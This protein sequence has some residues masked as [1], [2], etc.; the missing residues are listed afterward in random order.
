MNK[1][2]TYLALL[3]LAGVLTWMVWPGDSQAPDADTSLTTAPRPE[4]PVQSGTAAI[5]Q[6]S[7]SLSP[8]V[9]ESTQ[10][11]PATDQTQ[12]GAV[13]EAGTASIVS[14]RRFQGHVLDEAVSST[15]EPGVYRRTL[16][17][18]TDFHYPLVRIEETVRDPGTRREQILSSIEAVAGHILVRIREGVT[19]E[20]L[21]AL[22]EP[23]PAN[24]EKAHVLSRLYVVNIPARTVDDLPR[25]LDFLN[26][27]A[28]VEYAE[29]DG[30]VHAHLTEP[31]DPRYLD[32]TLW[33]LHN[34]GQD[35]GTA[36]KDIDAPE[37]WDIRHSAENVIVAVIDTGILYTHEDLAGNM[38][39]NTSELNGLPG[40][41]DDANGY[42]DDIYG[43]NSITEGGD[44]IDDNRHGTHCAGTIGG[45]GDNATGV[46]GV[47]WE[48]Q[49]M[50][51]K[52]LGAG[53]S[54][55]SSDAAECVIYAVANGASVLSNS[56]GGGSFNATLEA[57]IEQAQMAD[58]IFVAAAGNNG[59]N[60]DPAP[61]YPVA[62]PQSNIVGVASYNREGFRSSFS[63]YGPATIEVAAPGS[64]IF[65]STYSGDPTDIDAYEPLSGTSMATPHVSGIIALMRA[66]FPS[67][68]YQ[69]LINRLLDSADTTIMGS[70]VISGGANLPAALTG[71]PSGPYND[72]FDRARYLGKRSFTT[73]GTTLLATAEPGEPS[74]AGQPASHSVWF[75]WVA[76]MANIIDVYSISDEMDTRIAVYE[77]TSL[78]SLTEIASNDNDPDAVNSGR[79]SFLQFPAT[80]NQTYFIAVDSADGSTGS[81]SLSIENTP[82]NDDFA[83]AIAWSGT[84]GTFRPDNTGATKEPGEPRHGGLFGGS[85]LWYTFT[86][87][88]DGRLRVGNGDGSPVDLG[89]GIY[90]GTEVSALAELG[91]ARADRN[92]TANAYAFLEAGVPY[93]I[94]VDTPDGKES[95][96][97]INWAFTSNEIR[98]N[99][100]EV[101]VSE[102]DPSG[103]V[104]IPVERYLGTGSG[105]STQVPWGTSS[106]PNS[107]V[108]GLDYEE[109]S[110]VLAWAANEAG[111]KTISIPILD[112][113]QIQGDRVL[114]LTLGSPTN[115]AYVNPAYRRVK[116]TILDDD[117]PLPSMPGIDTGYSFQHDPLTVFAI[118]EAAWIPVTR[119]GDAS[120]AGSV[121]LDTSDDSALN[122]SDYVATSV[123]VDFEP[124]QTI[125]FVPVE[126]LSPTV[127]RRFLVS[128]SNPG[129]PASV[130]LGS[131]T[132]SVEFLGASTPFLDPITVLSRDN[133]S[134]TPP[135]AS[136]TSRVDVSANG[137]FTV[138]DSSTNALVPGD[139]NG[140][141][142]VFLR[143]EATGAL[144][145]VSTSRFGGAGDGDSTHP[146]ISSDGRYI[147]YASTANDIHSSDANEHSDI[148]IFDRITGETVLASVNSDGDQAQKKYVNLEEPVF[149]D[150]THPEI[151]G[152]GMSII[153]L[154][155]AT[156]LD[157]LH[158]SNDWD[159]DVFVRDLDTGVTEYASIDSNWID[160]RYD[161]ETAA[162]SH[163][164]QII[165]FT[166]NSPDLVPDDGNFT[167][168]DIFLRDR[169]TNTTSL[170]SKL[171]GGGSHDSFGGFISVA[172]SGNG[173]KIAFAT[174]IPGWAGEA[175]NEFDLNIFVRDIATG[176]ITVVNRDLSGSR[177]PGY[178]ADGQFLAFS[179]DGS[180]LAFSFSNPSLLPYPVSTSVKELLYVSHLPS[181]SLYVS[182][183][184]AD[185]SLAYGSIGPMA[186]T[187]DGASVVFSSDMEGL[188]SGG[189]PSSS[190]VFG[191]PSMVNDPRTRF[192]FNNS[193][194]QTLK[195]EGS[196]VIEIPVWRSGNLAHAV[197]IAYQT[198]A[199]TATAGIDY[200]PVSGSLNFAAGESMKS[201]SITTFNPEGS[202]PPRNFF[203]V[204]DDAPSDFLFPA[205]NRH[206]IEL[207][208]QLGLVTSLIRISRT[209][210]DTGG[211][212]N[213]DFPSLDHTGTMAVF[214]SNATNLVTEPAITTDNL[215]LFD[216]TDASLQLLP[217][218][219]HVPGTETGATYPV[220]SGDANWVAFRSNVSGLTQEG[221]VPSVYQLYLADL[222][223]GAIRLLS[224]DASGNPG[225]G[226]TNLYS[227]SSTTLD[228]RKHPFSVNED[229]R[230]VA[231]HSTAANLVPSDANS[232]SDIFLYDR[233]NDSLTRIDTAH[234]G[235]PSAGA[236]YNPSVSAD[237]R[238]V[239]FVSAKPDLVPDDTNGF[240]DV[241][242]YDRLT[243]TIE[244][245]SIADDEAEANGPSYNCSISGDGDLVAF[246]SSATNLIGL[247]DTNGY[248]DC[249]VRDMTSGTTT[250][251]SVTSNGTETVP[252]NFGYKLDG[253]SFGPAISADG[254]HVAFTS[255]AANLD[256][257]VQ[258][259]P[260]LQYYLPNEKLY[261]H[262]RSSGETTALIPVDNADAYAETPV[263]SAD[264]RIAAIWSQSAALI[265]NDNNARYDAFLAPNPSHPAV[266]ASGFALWQV[267]HFYHQAGNPEI[268]GVSADPEGDL[269]PNII[270]YVLGLNPI[271]FDTPIR[272][273]LRFG[274]DPLSD[275]LEFSFPIKSTIN[276]ITWR[277]AQSPSLEPGSWSFLGDE[278][279]RTSFSEDSQDMDRIHLFVPKPETGFRSFFQ[280]ELIP[281]SSI[282]FGTPNE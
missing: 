79:D 30:I 186:M 258:F 282:D 56:W 191:G 270:E 76:P 93:F 100:L 92:D 124:G 51:C 50:A 96:F 45:S 87:A 221:S 4:A 205:G 106:A 231:F 159:M 6:A 273:F 200:D 175:T 141:S 22:L 183:V 174:M 97:F 90:S 232:S 238:F 138:F 259:P 199:G 178:S 133:A 78:G 99:D 228:I 67:E 73:L 224:K 121:Q 233:D 94:A 249:F 15:D 155:D 58:V 145:L 132:A 88:Y 211:N 14:Q 74:H 111:I 82:Q 182:S 204:L 123:R 57:A 209:A 239:A 55:S 49:L 59:Q 213:S 108:D 246:D 218:D 189:N 198:E 48:V 84:G 35:E 171:P 149:T 227:G 194:S 126:L 219:P 169:N 163:D 127:G 95:W 116:I 184:A 225:N 1:P 122:G 32:G 151:S 167:K 241:F 168:D 268:G 230:F 274:E 240:A 254:G 196:S 210:T 11:N 243:G 91:G 242:R 170:L 188:A 280:L 105:S 81:F 139:N 7:P 8:I 147:A 207:L 18:Q 154:S 120:E 215:F 112:N 46:T 158:P 252:F 29:A 143:D 202:E 28:Q 131:G 9:P 261:L 60:I 214:S 220:I 146:S 203:L 2:L 201:I 27:Q 119:I 173:E 125:A 257:S 180:Y 77:G 70:S 85:S 66:Q 21:E 244:R 165:V 137:R 40:V 134:G 42:I 193:T 197:T 236:S 16:L 47:A 255:Y 80:N 281:A 117:N 164:G 190:D 110:G 263:L 31:N 113:P 222:R 12:G 235:G 256:P 253:N 277:I 5:P 69:S 24:I 185:D 262:N 53:G 264:G 102:D 192:F 26:K 10:A 275:D 129:S 135:G 115:G 23:I 114:Y 64:N 41:D 271:R 177:M 181:G 250:R 13:A 226:S 75:E 128:L 71:S 63:N 142:D 109:A 212:Q 260:V 172:V 38:W 61:Y 237:G 144:Q 176:D 248:A 272:P 36:D 25:A 98:L 130:V 195:Q 206:T 83:D 208:D 161:A 19:E 279:F 223:S 217:L 216:S 72:T 157:T 43:I 17:M 65:S 44:P 136:Q 234:D 150:S 162:L 89:I 39:T 68:S 266:S 251:V 62:Y 247:D 104:V 166:S 245:V 107:A 103:H 33:G 179:H 34:T 152:D 52:F 118:E 148:F 54:G 156:N 269:I 37:G 101:V 229:G 276:D 267:Q 278:T 86:P 3:T 20:E 187:P 140:R 160:D 265:A 153:F